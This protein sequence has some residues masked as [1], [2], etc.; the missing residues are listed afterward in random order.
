MPNKQLSTAALIAAVA[1]LLMAFVSLAEYA[2]GPQYQ[3]FYLSN[4]GCLLDRNTGDLYMA[5][6]DE[7][8]VLYATFDTD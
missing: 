5:L 3:R 7:K 2:T 1:L 6:G 8:W 4:D